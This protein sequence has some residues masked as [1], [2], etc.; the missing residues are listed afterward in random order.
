MNLYDAIYRRKSCRKYDMRPLPQETMDEIERAIAEFVPLYPGH[1]LSHHFTQKVKGPFQVEAPHYLVVTGE[2]APGEA[3]NAGFLYEQLALWFDTMEIGC[4][5]LGGS[6]AAQAERTAGEHIIAMGFGRA[7]EPVHRA[8]DGFKRRPIEAITNAPGDAR[9]QAVHAAPSGM[10]TQPW[11]LRQEEGRVYVYQQK[12][13]PPIS[14]VYKH[15]D[16][17]MGIGLCHYALAC[18]EMGKPFQFARETGMPE[19]AGYKPFGVITE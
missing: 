18:R 16:L 2:G 4:V 3:E 15:S 17:D 7:T 13:R 19:K 14:L 9:M 10:N 5:W 1:R 8:R 6:K 12:L 11:F